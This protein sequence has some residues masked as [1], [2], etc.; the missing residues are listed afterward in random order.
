[1][2][3]KSFQNALLPPSSL[4][5]Y[6]FLSITYYYPTCIRSTNIY[7]IYYIYLFIHLLH[8][9]IY[10]NII[11]ILCC[12]LCCRYWHTS[13][14]KIKILPLWDWH[15]NW[16]RPDNRHD[17]RRV[18]VVLESNITTGIENVET[19]NGDPP[20]CRS[21]NSNTKQ[22]FMFCNTG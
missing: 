3:S 21:I 14:R 12:S 2:F 18:F 22:N 17:N 8:L 4:T 6:I 20:T 1:M 7:F 9:S 11:C 19:D 16:G 10:Y 13:G 5:P 15:S